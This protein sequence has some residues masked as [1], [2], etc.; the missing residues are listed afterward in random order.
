MNIVAASRSN[1]F[2]YFSP[3]GLCM[4]RRAAMMLVTRCEAVIALSKP[5]LKFVRRTVYFY[6]LRITRI[7][8]LNVGKTKVG[9]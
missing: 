5:R 6:L 4:I 8:L 2:G 7:E 9:S 1:L 3:M